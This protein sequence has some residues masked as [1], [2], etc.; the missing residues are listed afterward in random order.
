MFILPKK[1]GAVQWVEQ[2]RNVRPAIGQKPRRVWRAVVTL[3]KAGDVGQEDVFY[4]FS[5]GLVKV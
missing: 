4:G 2:P 3:W 1:C 5:R